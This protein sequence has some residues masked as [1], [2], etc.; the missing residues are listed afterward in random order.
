MI[1]YADAKKIAML[2]AAIGEPTRLRILF[3]LAH[4]PQNVGQLAKAVGIP[5]VNM[6]HH[7][8]VMR[9]TGLLE[10][11]KDGRRVVYRFRPGLF[12]PNNHVDSPDALGTLIIGAYR[13]VL[14]RNGRVKKVRRSS[15]SP[16]QG[17]S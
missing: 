7:L 9:Q 11:E 5:M 2:L 15:S 12:E 4:Q 8:G 14:L 1:E 3:R 13:V 6:S 16:S 10:D 17:A